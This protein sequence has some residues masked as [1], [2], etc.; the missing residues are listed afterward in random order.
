MSCSRQ[1]DKDAKA[2]HWHSDAR[3]PGAL[4]QQSC[5]E[6]ASGLCLIAKPLGS[7]YLARPEKATS[8]VT[9]HDWESS[10]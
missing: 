1:H 8:P 10:V 7:E 5:P 2:L 9:R 4:V 3:S 6:R